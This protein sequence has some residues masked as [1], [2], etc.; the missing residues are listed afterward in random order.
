MAGDP[1]VQDGFLASIEAKIAALQALADSYRAALSVG[2][3]GQPAEAVD[4]QPVLPSNLNRMASA[5]PVELPTGAFRGTGIA[6]AI[7]IYLEAA[8]RKQT[9]KQISEALREGGI[10]STSADFEKTL[11]TTLHRLK[12]TGELI[13]FKDGWDLASSYPESF[14]QRLAKDKLPKLPR[15]KIKKA[16]KLRITKLAKSSSSVSSPPSVSS[17]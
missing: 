9:F 3:I 8:R 1:P 2:A 10:V 17:T 7:R 5:G 16:K 14:K 13:Q 6:A 12:G 15:L 11:S 4:G